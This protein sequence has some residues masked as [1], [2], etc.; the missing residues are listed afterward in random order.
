MLHRLKPWLGEWWQRIFSWLNGVTRGGFGILVDAARSYARANAAEAAAG[1]AFYALFSVFPLLG[2]LVTA[3][4]YFVPQDQWFGV[5]LDFLTPIFPLSGTLIADNL[6]RFIRLRGTIGV[7]GTLGLLWSAS[8]VFSILVHH[9][10]NAW[11]KAKLRSFFQKRLIAL[12]LIAGLVA[13]FSFFWMVT[14]L[15]GV[16]AEMR[17]PVLSDPAIYQSLPWLLLTEAIPPLIAFAIFFVLYRWIPT[18]PVHWS[19]AAWGALAVTILWEITGGL[20]GLYIGSGLVAFDVLYG[21]LAALAIL[22][23]WFYVNSLIV[24]FGAYLCAKIGAHN[25]MRREL[26]MHALAGSGHQ[27]AAVDEK[28]EPLK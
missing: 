1:L 13:L 3:V 20:F 6:E 11:E 10:N 5:L 19:E 15:L 23:I 21:S 28:R 12:G 14:W 26:A 2:I 27:P 24:L 17:L 16:L 18:T 22:M 9:I 8:N 7:I 4:S 25:M